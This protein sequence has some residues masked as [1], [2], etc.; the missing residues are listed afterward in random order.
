MQKTLYI[1]RSMHSVSRALARNTALQIVGKALGTLLSLLTF[2]LLVRYLD[3]D[4][5]GALT[6]ALNYGT[7]LAILVDFGLTLT[8]AQMIAEPDA[9]ESR[10]LGGVLT[11]RV[12]SALV[13]LGG[14]AA[15]VF[16]FP[17]ATEVKIAAALSCASF[18]FGT[19]ATVFSGVFQ[20]R[21]AMRDVVLAE[22]LNRAVVCALAASLPF[23]G[24]SVVMGSIIFVA[25]SLVQLVVTAAA[26]TRLTSIRPCVDW[27]VWRG[28]IARSWPIGV[29]IAL[30]LVYL[31]GD[32]FFLSIF[33]V[34]DY[35]I[36]LYGAAYKVV[37]VT[38]TVPVMFMGLMLPLLAHARA[39]NNDGA[40]REHFQR[41]FD[42]LAMLGIPFAFGAIAVGGP[43]LGMLKPDLAAAGPLLAILGPATALVFFGS[44]FG[45]TIVA[46]HKQRMMIWGYFATAVLGLL[47]YVTFIPLYGT[48]AAAWVTL[49]CEGLIMLLTAGVVFAST[50]IALSLRRLLQAGT[51]S[52]VMFVVL[53]LVAFPHVLIAIAAGV[54]VYMAALPLFGGPSPKHMLALLVA[55]DVGN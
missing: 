6:I 50:R 26:A 32:I 51:A 37:D 25:G 46:L 55:P 36:G 4:G 23:L 24:V 20:K 33:G 5:W 53:D 21:L 15:A 54:G 1:Q 11:L 3:T 27:G 29:A 7:I 39:G 43:L 31:R 30:N 9:D 2:V 19:V 13:F 52:I 38:T 35:D 12:V 22:T 47:G 34:S 8:T 40:F 28:A 16:A 18:F 41:A 45:H 49:A 10:I 44:L 14:G 17:Y 48:I 42:I